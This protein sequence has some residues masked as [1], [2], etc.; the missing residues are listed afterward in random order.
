MKGGFAAFFFAFGRVFNFYFILLKM[1]FFIMDR[2]SILISFAPAHETQ[3][4][5][6]F[7]WFVFASD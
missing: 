4:E 3:I 1:I 2:I 6:A 7:S 5:E